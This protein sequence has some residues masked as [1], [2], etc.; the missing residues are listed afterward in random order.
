M[1][2]DLRKPSGDTWHYG[3][4]ARVTPLFRHK[5]LAARRQQALGDVLQVQPLAPRVLTLIAMALACALIAFGYWGEYTRK[6]HVT[7]YLVPTAG[8]IKIYSR[9]TGT[10]VDKQ[11]SEGQQL[12]K[13]DVLFV[14]SMERRSSES[15]DTQGAA[16][17]E[18][19][20]RR[21]TLSAEILQHDELI[22]LQD[23]SLRQRI[24]AMEGELAQLDLELATQTQSVEV[25][26]N[27]FKRYLNLQ[28]QTLVSEEM[29]EERR[30][31]VLEQEGRLHA[32]QRNRI[33]VAKEIE[34]LRAQIGSA[35][36]Q[37]ETQRS[38]M[39]RDVSQL[40]QELTEYE[41]RRTIVVTA[42]SSGTATAVLAELGQSMLAGQPM[43]SILPENATLTAHLIVPS[44]SIGFLAA[45]QT[46]SL[47]YQAFP[48]QR[49]GSYRA[50]VTEVSRSL[51]MPNEAVLPIPLTEPAYR[52]TVVLDS[53]VV[54]AYGQDLPLQ[55][56]MI[57]DADIWLDRRRLYE[58]VLDPL[59]SVL[60][61]V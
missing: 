15:I 4:A 59:Y 48:Y 61:R 57:V 38:A 17:A 37:A 18:L 35:R 26:Q 39:T 56:G 49:F 28:S 23:R 40:S 43:L 58:W 27:G 1:A 3:S 50:R 12:S 30:G 47:R 19:A 2:D 16:I 20:Q 45:G 21:S 41:S 25:A 51:I 44:Q 32:L 31:V 52:V 54:K 22:V 60:G 29:V 42:P 13:G 24:S 5:A 34:A 14:V 9:E 36:L 8:L 10:I 46:V 6:A 11:V 55:A 7:G 53:Q 33:S